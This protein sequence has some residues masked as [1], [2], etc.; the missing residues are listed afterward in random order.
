MRL[1]NEI[2]PTSFV[3][4][5]LSSIVLV[6]VLIVLLLLI[7]LIILFLLILILIIHYLCLHVILAVLR[8]VSLPTMLGFILCFE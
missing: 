2:P 4:G 3:G 8:L 7:L 1:I 6:F 5:I